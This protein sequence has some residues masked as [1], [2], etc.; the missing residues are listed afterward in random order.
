MVASQRVRARRSLNS[1]AA[2]GAGARR[3]GA[4][5]VTRPD[6]GRYFSRLAER[7]R[8]AEVAHLAGQPVDDHRHRVACVINEQFIATQVGLAHRHQKLGFPAAVEFAKA[9]VVDR[10]YPR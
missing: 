8:L 7:D 1:R 5:S 10:C 4:G 3:Q 6:P 2:S 9:G